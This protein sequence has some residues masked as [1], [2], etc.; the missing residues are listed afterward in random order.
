MAK[1]APLEPT[2]IARAE[3]LG[4]LVRA[5]RHDAGLDQA[6]AAGIAGVGVRFLGD[7]ERGKPTVRFDL[8]LRVLERLGLEL[9]ISPRSKAKA[10]T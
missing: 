1:L 6:T 4:R 9:M 7:I 3:D 5:V 2:R 8:V 10:R